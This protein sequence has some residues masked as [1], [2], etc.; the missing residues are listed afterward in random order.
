[1]YT[2]LLNASFQLPLFYQVLWSCKYSYLQNYFTQSRIYKFLSC[3][4]NDCSYWSWNN[5]TTFSLFQNLKYYLSCLSFAIFVESYT[6][7]TNLMTSLNLRI[8][9]M[10]N[11]LISFER[12]LVWMKVLEKLLIY[13]L[14]LLRCGRNLDHKTKSLYFDFY[15]FIFCFLV[16]IQII[17]VLTIM[18]ILQNAQTIFQSRFGYYCD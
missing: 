4:I 11:L 9:H 7:L 5:F 14:L 8:Y 15:I 6:L 1:M 17:D 2:S 12:Y 18:V 16:Q 10:V 3:Q 13:H